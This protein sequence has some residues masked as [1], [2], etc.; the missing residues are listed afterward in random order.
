[1]RHLIGLMIVSNTMKN[2]GRFKMNRDEM[3]H[4]ACE[5]FE[6]WA[7]K[8]TDK[9]VTDK[10]FFEELCCSIYSGD[11]LKK[12][13]TTKSVI[14]LDEDCCFKYKGYKFELTPCTMLASKQEVLDTAKLFLCDGTKGIFTDRYVC[15]MTGHRDNDGHTK[16]FNCFTPIVYLVPGAWAYGAEYDCQPGEKVDE[17][18]LDAIDK[19]LE[20]SPNL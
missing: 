13:E 15:W 14:K 5:R 9:N 2:T 4:A 12:A 19:F 8:Y 11:E 10:Q 16:D 6:S 17:L 3:W 20:Q 1:M 7:C 18:I